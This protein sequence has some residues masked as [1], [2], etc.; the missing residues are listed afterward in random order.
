MKNQWLTFITGRV[1]VKAEGKGIERLINR[2]AQSG[3]IMWKVKKRKSGDVL[4]FIALPDLHKFRNAARKADC[5]ITLIRGVGLPFIWKR[6]F[7]H[8]GFLVGIVLFF[9]IAFILSN[10]TWGIEIKGADPETEHK[11]RKELTQLGIKVGSFHLFSDKPDMIQQKLTEKIDNITWIG[12]EL[13]G[14]TFH[15]S[16]VQKNDPKKPELKN[17]SHLV[18]K[19]KA[20]ISS[21]FVEKGKSMVKVNQY[22]EKGQ[23]LVSGMI[24]SE[25]KPK[26][27][28]ATGE[29][30]GITWYNTKV[31]FPLNSNFKVY[32]GQEIRRHY[33]VF[34]KLS[35]RLWGFKSVDF[36]QYETET[37][38]HD[39]FF[40]GWKLPIVYSERTIRENEQMPR[41]L[42]KEEA[43]EEAK[44]LARSDLENNIPPEARVDGE[45][46]LQ[47][48]VDNGKVKLSIN[49]QVVENIAEERPIIQGD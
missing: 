31:E 24:G 32:T 22:V 43:I 13:K 29:V 2:L 19:K 28:S 35:L 26:L 45:Y 11:M 4:F 42:T 1:L 40:L 49:F 44:E 18:A 9:L 10:V 15:F 46:I 16:V 6:A 23:L 5:T 47:Q 20:V 8:S 36:K 12:V 17:P 7:K 3:L 30:W 27:V 48:E 38:D 34:G 14:T 41:S 21:M 33:L 39:L 37:I 25:E